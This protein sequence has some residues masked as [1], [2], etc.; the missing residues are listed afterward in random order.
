MPRLRGE[1]VMMRALHRQDKLAL[2]RNFG[3]IQREVHAPGVINH[4]AGGQN[5][6]VVLHP[7]PTLWI[8]R[9]RWQRQSACSMTT[10]VSDIA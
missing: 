2:K 10:V 6:C 9:E 5:N 8:C 1:V 4:S 7:F 3:L